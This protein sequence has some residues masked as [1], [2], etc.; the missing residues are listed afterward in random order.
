MFVLDL[1]IYLQEEA[2]PDPIH[3]DFQDGTHTDT[4]A[5]SL[6]GDYQ[7]FIGHGTFTPFCLFGTSWQRWRRGPGALARPGAQPPPARAGLFQITRAQTTP[8]RAADVGRAGTPRRLGCTPARTLPPRRPG[9]QPSRTHPPQREG[10]ART[11]DNPAGAAPRPNVPYGILTAGAGHEDQGGAAQHLQA[12]RRQPIERAAGGPR[13]RGGGSPSNDQDR[14]PAA[15][16][17]GC[18][19]WYGY[20]LLLCPGCIPGIPGASRWPRSAW[21]ALIGRSCPPRG[22]SGDPFSRSAAPILLAGYPGSN[23]G[24]VLVLDP[25]LLAVFK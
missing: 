20:K 7:F 12:Q 19:S 6:Q 22:G 1:L 17:P 13:L 3:E 21:P 10:P 2:A 14:R 23:R 11:N 25:A 15:S 5:F 8:E 18:A 16:W 4:L 9:G 24:N